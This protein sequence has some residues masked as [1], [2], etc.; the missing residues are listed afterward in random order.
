MNTRPLILLAIALSSVSLLL[1]ITLLTRPNHKVNPPSVTVLVIDA[2]PP[3][4]DLAPEPSPF[5]YYGDADG[6]HS[7]YIRGS[8]KGLDPNTGDFL[9]G[10]A[11]ECGCP[12]TEVGGNGPGPSACQTKSG[13]TWHIC[14]PF[15]PSAKWCSTYA[16]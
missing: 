7:T 4:D 14:N 6:Y 11:M 1:G 8:I 10:V 12:S 2:E 13:H 3:C 5:A 9:C 15:P 16:K